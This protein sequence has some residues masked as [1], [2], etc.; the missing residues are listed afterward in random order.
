MS[1]GSEGLEFQTFSNS[2]G[3]NTINSYKWQ[4]GS[5]WPLASRAY[6][7]LRWE[8]RHGLSRAASIGI[9]VVILVV[10]VAAAI[11]VL[12]N[13][14]QSSTSSSSTT[15]TSTGSTTPT[16]SS[17]AQTTSTSSGS[18]TSGS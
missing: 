12:N 4:Q 13:G 9:V 5:L 3:R 1:A 14:A 15:T 18:A 2:E 6:A 17:S 7:Q 8:S 11:L 10:L 16:S